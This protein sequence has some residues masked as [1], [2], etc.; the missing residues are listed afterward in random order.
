MREILAVDAQA[1]TLVRPAWTA[2]R[3]TA[4]GRFST[5]TRSRS[6]RPPRARARRAGRPRRGRASGG[7]ASRGTAAATRRRRPRSARRAPGAPVAREGARDERA[8]LLS[9]RQFVHRS[10]R[11]G[12][13]AP[14][15]P[16]RGATAHGPRLRSGRH[17]PRRASGPRGDDLLDGRGDLRAERRAAA[18]RT[19][20]ASD[21]SSADGGR[22]RDGPALPRASAIRAAASPASTCR[23]RSG[24][25]APR[26]RRRA[27]GGRRV[28][29]PAP[30]R[31]RT[32]PRWP[33]AMA[34]RGGRRGGRVRSSQEPPATH[35]DS[36]AS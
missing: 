30:G 1:H 31:T 23:S 13:P 33:P 32:R 29:A 15:I 26:T 18:A 11:R 5:T 20:A 12:P 34:H 16:E 10:L 4:R 21:R 3:R 27:H 36:C 9:S 24:R 19:R 35:R 22:R 7:R 6:W 17:H 8:L 2:A 14:R 25:R 28:R